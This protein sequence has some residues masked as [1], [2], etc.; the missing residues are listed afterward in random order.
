M[1]LILVLF[2]CSTKDD[3]VDMI[4]QLE[5]DLYS[6]TEKAFDPEIAEN[7]VTQYEQFV[8]SNPN[9]SLAAS[10]LF[11]GAELAMSM[12]SSEK[13]I[14]LYN[15]VYK[16][17]P[18]YAKA[19]TAVFLIGFVNETQIKNLAEAQKHYRKFIADYPNHNLIDDAKFSLDNLGKSDEDI[20]K[21]FEAKLAK[22]NQADSL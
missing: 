20:I 12:S 10:Y 5:I 14:E 4:N 11:K 18:D 9:D 16:E 6:N 13:S 19:A 21:E 1:S 3:S 7:L 8:E 17:Y 22:A 15:R 2:A